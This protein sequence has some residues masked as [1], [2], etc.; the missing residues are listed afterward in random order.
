MFVVVCRCVQVCSGW[1]VFVSIIVVRW[2][3][4]VGVLCI[5]MYV[6]CCGLLCV[7]VW[8]CTLVCVGLCRF[9]RICADV[10]VGVCVGVCICLYMCVLKR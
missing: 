6:C 4:L 1:C 5:C 7:A 9:V 8:F 2:C 3:E 10:C